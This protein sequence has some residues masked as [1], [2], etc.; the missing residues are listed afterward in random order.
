MGITMMNAGMNMF[1]SLRWPIK[2]YQTGG[3]VT[4]GS[5]VK[6]D[7]LTMMQ[8]STLLEKALLIKY[9]EFLLWML[10]IGPGREIDSPQE[11][12]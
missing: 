6:D 2:K 1:K 9:R 11:V 5:G 12:A 10:L 4:G 3:L 7:V 8:G